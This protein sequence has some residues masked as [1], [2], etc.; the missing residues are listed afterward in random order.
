[1]SEY[2]YLEKDGK[3]VRVDIDAGMNI[4]EFL[5]SLV[6]PGECYSSLPGEIPKEY[7]LVKLLK[8]LGKNLI[9]YKVLQCYSYPE[10]SKDKCRIEVKYEGNPNLFILV[11]EDDGRIREEPCSAYVKNLNSSFAPSLR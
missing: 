3:D 1:M 6:K 5:N 7:P 8:R 10:H 2:N 9:Y 4:N 11:I